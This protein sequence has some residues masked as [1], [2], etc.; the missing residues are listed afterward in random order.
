VK[1]GEIWSELEES[2][3]SSG[4]GR[5][6]RR[7]EAGS[8]MDLNV[9]LVLPERHRAVSLTVAADAVSGDGD[10]PQAAG[11]SHVLTSAG[12]NGRVTFSLELTDRAAADLFEVLVEDLITAVATAG[13]DREGVGIWTGR[14]V[15][16]QHLLRQAPH[17]LGAELQ[18]A[19]MAE[20]WILRELIAPATDVTAAVRAWRGPDRSRHDFQLPLTSLEVKSCAAN[21]P[22]V[23]MINGERQLDDVGTPALHLA[24]VS[25][26][27]HHNGP[28]SLLEVV[29][30]VRALAAG[31]EAE[32]ELE[33]RLLECGFL[34]L[35]A[36]RYAGTGYTVRKS[37]FFRVALGFPR[38][39]EADLPD[40][41][42]GLRYRLAIAACADFEVEEDAIRSLI[43]GGGK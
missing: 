6:R 34:D 38:L 42:G 24:H 9:E 12:A 13:E 32:V 17:G 21:Q 39:T 5:L 40:G 27:V 20:L 41:I 18:R 37:R 31:S 19:L 35:H 2:G 8:K 28:E 11:L 30:S 14:I 26:D 43:G 1:P 15:R 33:D 25:L 36:P 22:Q 7:V 29:A 23:V 3:P 10:P 16:W 4:L